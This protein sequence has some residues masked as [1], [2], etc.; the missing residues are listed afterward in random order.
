MQVLP[1]MHQ[2]TFA[3]RRSDR[4]RWGSAFSR[5]QEVLLLTALKKVALCKFGPLKFDSRSAL[6]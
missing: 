6:E 2:N 3:D 4:T 1:K 5:N